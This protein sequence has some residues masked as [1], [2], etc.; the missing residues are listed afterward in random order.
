MDY[1]T[2]NSMKE[3]WERSELIVVGR[4]V[5]AAPRSYNVSRDLN[6]P[7]KPSQTSYY[8]N[9]V[10]QFE[11]EA[12]LK[13]NETRDTIEV[14]QFHGRVIDEYADPVDTFVEPDLNT[15]KVLFLS[16]HEHV[17]HYSFEQVS[18]WLSTAPRN[19]M[20][21]DWKDLTFA[22]QGKGMEP[23]SAEWASQVSA[24]GIDLSFNE[25]N[26]AMRSNI[27][28]TSLTGAELLTLAE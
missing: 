19:E 21:P 8:E 17:D 7:S 28:C 18:W 25:G 14:G 24:K 27:A 4:Y 12:V 2:T 5:N 23:M 26:V 20:D 11:V 15:Y 16:E 1:D 9:L 22:P 6:D 10:Y 3:L 13:G